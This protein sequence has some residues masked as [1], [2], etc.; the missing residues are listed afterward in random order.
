MRNAGSGGIGDHNE[1]QE[2]DFSSGIVREEIA[3]PDCGRDRNDEGGDDPPAAD[4]S[5][6][7][8]TRCI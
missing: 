5:Y 3:S 8:I 4:R 1:R 7:G 2:K 6:I